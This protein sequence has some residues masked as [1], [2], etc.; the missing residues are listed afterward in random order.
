MLTTTIHNLTDDEIHGIADKVR[1]S[2]LASTKQMMIDNDLEQA[3]IDIYVPL[4]ASL[5]QQ[6]EDHHSSRVIGINGAQGSGKTTLCKL[7]K[8]V[9]E[10]GFAKRVAAF[11]I[12]DIYLTHAER[13]TL[14]KEI[15]P[16]LETRGVPGTHDVT[17]GLDLLA[18][19]RELKSGQTISIPLFDKAI[20]DRSAEENFRQVTGPI[21]LVLF[22][23]WCVGVKAQREEALAIAVNSLERLEDPDQI[24]RSYVNKQL[25]KGYKELFNQIDF[26]VMLKI[27]GMKSVMEWRS[28]QENKLGRTSA[29][30]GRKIMNTAELQRFIM[31]YERLTRAT[32]TEM[33]D[34]ADLVFELDEKHLISGVKINKR[35][36][37]GIA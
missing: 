31:H 22:E 16:L 12:D 37:K 5:V 18:G 13:K 32:L 2:F 11:S 26:L 1:P 21:D 33:P 14:A 24:W 19:L 20:D 17:L 28:K 27:P 15:H 35:T 36:H 3:L 30:S 25:Q 23:G 7:L 8:V 4:A 9:I 6:T 10:E 29:Q 34:R